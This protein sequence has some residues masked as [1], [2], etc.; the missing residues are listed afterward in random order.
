MCTRMYS[1][2]T[3][4]WIIYH[5]LIFF[6]LFSS[7]HSP[8]A[9]TQCDPNPCF[10]GGTC[11]SNGASCADFTCQC[12]GCYTDRNCLTGM[13]ARSD[14]F[15]FFFDVTNRTLSCGVIISDGIHRKLVELT[16]LGDV[17]P[18]PSSFFR[19]SNSHY[20]DPIFLFTLCVVGVAKSFGTEE[21]ASFQAW[22]WHWLCSITVIESS[23]C[24]LLNK[25][26]YSTYM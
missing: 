2:S 8:P 19:R 25:D 21:I 14:H 24:Y 11:S 13:N 9:I 16:L 23:M 18:V 15:K 12:A 22:R 20:G 5:T 17:S 26:F 10:N 1:L 3:C 4:L 6:S 7:F